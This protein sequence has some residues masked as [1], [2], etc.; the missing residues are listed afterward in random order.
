MGKSI[1]KTMLTIIV[2]ALSVT[3]SYAQPEGPVTIRNDAVRLT[4]NPSVGRIVDFRRIDGP[5]LMRITD[6]SVLTEAKEES[7]SYRGYGGDQLWPAQQATWGAI[8]GSGGGW[9]PLG[10]LDGPNWTIKNQ[11]THHITIEAPLTPLLGLQV[12]RKIELIPDSAD[13]KIT[14]QFKRA[15]EQPDRE[16]DVMIWSVTGMIEPEFTMMGISSDRPDE[17]RLWTNLSGRADSIITTLN[18]DT[19]LRFDVQAHGPGQELR[20]NSTKIGTHGDWLAAIYESDILLQRSEYQVGGNF[21][22]RASIEIY[23]SQNS[24]SEYIELE[25]LSPSINLELGE[26][27]SNIVYWHLLERPRDLDDGQLAARL[28]SVPEPQS[29]TMLGLAMLWF[30]RITLRLSKNQF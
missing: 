15:E 21:P 1:C 22:D 14:N 5:N 13:V 8:R 11:G 3:S 19:A 25:V 7:N 17:S 27:L 16:H 20:A 28:Q 30:V 12:E 6:P 29:F 2:A 10:E 26:T 9:P 4:V 23:S 18:E 24:G